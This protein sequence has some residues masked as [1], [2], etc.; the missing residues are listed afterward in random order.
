MSNTKRK[1]WNQRIHRMNLHL[2]SLKKTH[3]LL[4]TE[5]DKMQKK[6]DATRVGALK[7]KKLHL[8]DEITRLEKELNQN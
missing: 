7:V 1:D 8:K 2:E 5:V 3:A 4:N 6:G